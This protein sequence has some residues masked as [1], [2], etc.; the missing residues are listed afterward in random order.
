MSAKKPHDQKPAKG[1]LLTQSEAIEPHEIT[2]N[3]NSDQISKFADRLIELMNRPSGATREKADA[4]AT[5][6]GSKA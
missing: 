2:A 6:Q 3:M 5:T 4:I 1:K